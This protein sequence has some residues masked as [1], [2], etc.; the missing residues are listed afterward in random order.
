ML[1]PAV[2]LAGLLAGCAGF[3]GAGLK[4]GVATEAE[5]EKAMGPSAE[6]RQVAG[7]TVLFYSRL[8][9]GREMY[10]ARFGA[11]GRLIAIEQRLTR[12]NAQMLV[13]RQSTREDVRNLFGPPFRVDDYPRLA[14]QV[15]LYP[16]HE[17]A[18]RYTLNVDFTADGRVYEVKLYD[19]VDP[20]N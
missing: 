14:R 8:P 3:S 2:F 16:M 13:A 1:R 11:D 4:P 18:V 19:E 6:R 15:W 12:E 7:E 10:A 20:D 9:A 17:G 5:V